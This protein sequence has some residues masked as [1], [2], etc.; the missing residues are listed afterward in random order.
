P[1]PPP[2]PPP[3]PDRV[4]EARA[5]IATGSPE[6]CVCPL[7]RVIAAMRDPSPEFAERLA[8]GAGDLATGLAGVLR[9]FGTAME[10]TRP[11]RRGGAGRGAGRGVRH[12]RAG[13]R[14]GWRRGR[15]AVTLTIGVDVGGTKVLAGVVDPDG[16]VLA[17]ARRATPAHDPA[18]TLQMIDEVIAELAR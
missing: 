4:A 9:A 7:C 15:G 14:R 11:A 10:Q 13:G 1:P 16:K 2:P 6:C 3:R 12:R 18:K 5:G 17:T 8:T